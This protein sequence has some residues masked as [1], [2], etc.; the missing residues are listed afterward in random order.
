MFRDFILGAMLAISTWVTLAVLS[1]SIYR[2]T[3]NWDLLMEHTMQWGIMVSI[4]S[5]M[6]DYALC[7]KLGLKWR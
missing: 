1:L 4:A 7:K 3:G 6:I 5:M 2:Y